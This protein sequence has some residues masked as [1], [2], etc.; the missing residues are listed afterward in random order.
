MQNAEVMHYMVSQTPC[1]THSGQSLGDAAHLED[2]VNG[3]KD[4]EVGC[5]AHIALVGREAEHCDCNPLLKLGLF[6]QPAVP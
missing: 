1:V 3:A 6:G 4:V 2:L 5:C